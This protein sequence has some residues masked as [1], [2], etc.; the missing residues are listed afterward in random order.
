LPFSKHVDGDLAESIANAYFVKN[1]YWVFRTNQGHSA[2]D[3]ICVHESGEILLLDIKKDAGRTNP[4]DGGKR[5]ARMRS[6]LQK[7]L[8]VKLCYVNILTG[9]VHIAEHKEN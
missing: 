4:K 3:L 8:G 9:S 2:I 6:D 7:S 5:I 1:G